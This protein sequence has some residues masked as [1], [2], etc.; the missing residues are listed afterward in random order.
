MRQEAQEYH[1]S[2]KIHP[3]MS[4]S[5]PATVMPVPAAWPVVS[6]DPVQHFIPTLGSH[7]GDVH[8]FGL[9]ALGALFL[10]TFFL[11]VRQFGQ[12][13]TADT[14]LDDVKGHNLAN[15]GR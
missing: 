8:Q 9:L 14:K 5:P 2:R 11:P 4:L 6:T 3:Q 1:L 15:S 12:A 13:V 10:E 7:A